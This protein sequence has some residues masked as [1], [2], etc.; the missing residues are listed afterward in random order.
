MN[1][2]IIAVGK[3]RES[4]WRDASAEY[5]K[6]LSC[7]GQIRVIEIDEARLPDSPKP[8]EIAAALQKEG[9]RILEKVPKGAFY[10]LCVEGKMFSSE[11]L[12]GFLEKMAESGTRELV[13]IIGGA[14]GLSPEVK[15]SAALRLSFSKMTF[16]HQLVRVLLL[17]Q[18]YR[19]FSINHNGKYHK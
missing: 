9:R 11:Q 16:P 10:A 1:I 6:R 12:A 3:Q 17:E 2:T 7:F 4:F 19:S 8:M 15:E 13:F 14:W 5:M 18:L